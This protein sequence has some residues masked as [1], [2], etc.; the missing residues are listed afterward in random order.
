[1]ATLTVS[2]VTPNG[3]VYEQS[4]VNLVVLQTTSG[5]IGFMAN[6]VPTVVALKVGEVR[7]VTEDASTG[8]KHTK[9][10]AVTE[11]FAEVHKEQVNILV[12]AAELAEKI[13]I[14]R[15][16]QAVS[17]AQSRLDSSQENI[18][19]KRAELAL[20]RALNRLAV[21]SEIK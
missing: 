9:F 2:V 5:E 12:Q 14:E 10:L 16:K 15:A 19:Q 13:D 6:H 3:V 7:I 21:A 11:G 17:R 18:D 20:L 1:M 8:L 4:D